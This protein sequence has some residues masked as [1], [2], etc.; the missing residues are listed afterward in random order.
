MKYLKAALAAAVLCC[1]LVACGGGGISAGDTHVFS[2]PF[3]VAPDT[4]PLAVTAVPIPWKAAIARTPDASS[5]LN[6]AESA[7][8]NYFPS[9]QSNK[10][11]DVWTY[12]YY[13]QTD[14]Y[15]G[16]N[17]SGDVLGLVGKSGGAYDSIPLGKIAD[18][19]CQVD[20]AACPASVVKPVG[21]FASTP[22]GGILAHPQLR[23]VL[24]RVDWRSIEP[25]PGQFDLRVIDEQLA[26]VRAAGVAWSLAVGAGGPGSPAWLMDDLGAAQ[27]AYTFRGTPM[28]LPLFWDSVVQQRL[29]VLAQRLGQAYG[30]DAGLKLVYVPQMTA[31]GIEGHLN[32]V[33]MASLRSA[34]YTDDRWVEAALSVSREFATAFPD[35]ALAFEVHEIDRSATVPQRILDGL[36]SDETLGRRVGAAMWWISGRTDYQTALIGVLQN[37]QG[38]LYGQVI[39]RSD[40]NSQFGNSD[41]ASVFSQAKQLRMR[42][43]EPWE[44]DFGVGNGTANGRWDALLKDFNDWADAL[45]KQAPR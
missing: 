3:P 29:S 20:P 26:P 19:G 13:P 7:Y 42:Y 36:W 23:G 43:I 35:K 44:Y 28:R 5:F 4:G 39:A 17:T 18:Y 30:K 11:L 24:V 1:L 8:P 10:I 2:Q 37:W 6:W 14:I 16:T 31:N 15:L 34:G 32:G 9:A 33:D 40:Q 22:R 12:R 41:Y 21:T 25:Q 38:E 27:F 45:P